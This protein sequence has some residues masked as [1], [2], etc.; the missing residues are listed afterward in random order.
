MFC[1]ESISC[2][3][4]ILHW[5]IAI[6]TDIKV[7]LSSVSFWLSNHVVWE[8]NILVHNLVSWATCASSR[9]KIPISLV[10]SLSF[11]VQW[12]REM[13]SLHVMFVFVFVNILLLS[14]KE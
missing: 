3:L 10:P 4:L 2:S 14:S 12:V 8:A 13:V 9:R 1:S 7:A 5:Y 11:K 6:I